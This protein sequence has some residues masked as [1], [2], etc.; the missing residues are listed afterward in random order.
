[1]ATWSLTAG[2]TR[3]KR[4]SRTHKD[5]VVAQLVSGSALFAAAVL[6][7]AQVPATK[8]TLHDV[9]GSCRRLRSLGRRGSCE[10]AETRFWSS[11]DPNTGCRSM[12]AVQRYLKAVYARW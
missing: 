2:A 6:A 10:V 12:R 5:P 1:M 4:G 7:Q 11:R 3:C 8:A 9:L